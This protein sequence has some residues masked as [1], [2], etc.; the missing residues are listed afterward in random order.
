MK[1]YTNQNN[2]STLKLLIAANLA[3]KKVELV[4]ASFEGRCIFLFVN[5]KLIGFGVL[6][7]SRLSSIV[8]FIF[9]CISCFGDRCNTCV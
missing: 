4:S 5:R 9:A 6:G 1:I 2:T 3:G 8:M 7:V